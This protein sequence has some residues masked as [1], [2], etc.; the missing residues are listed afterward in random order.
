VRGQQKALRQRFFF[1]GKSH[2]GTGEKDLAW[3]AS[4][5]TEV[6]AAVWNSAETRTV[7]MYLAGALR[8][9]GERG[10]AITVPSL[11][12]ILHSAASLI[13]FTMPRAPYGPAYEPIVDTNQADGRPATARITPPGGVVLVPPRSV[14]LYQT[15]SL[16][17]M[18]RRRGQRR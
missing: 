3:F 12:A 1:E 2:N 5:G 11:F 9:R 10:E 15:V 7:G 14:L 16:P 6:P 18:E 13:E 17:P 8:T 4:D